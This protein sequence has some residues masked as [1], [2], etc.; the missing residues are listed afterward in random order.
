MVF[1]NRAS[2]GA[3][4]SLVL[5]LTI[6]GLWSIAPSGA[7]AGADFGAK[8]LMA[9]QGATMKECDA[10]PTLVAIPGG[11]FMMGSEKS[12]PGHEKDESPR[13]E[14]TIRPFAI[15]QTEVTVGE[16]RRFSEE[17]GR[18]IHPRLRSCYTYVTTV[19]W[20][21]EGNYWDSPGFEQSD[22]HPVVC[23]STED[24]EDYVA[25]LNS[26][27]EGDPYR[28]PSE[29]EWEY[30]ARAGAKSAFWWGGQISSDQA[31]YK[32]DLVYDKG[33]AGEYRGGTLPVKSFKPNPFGLYQ[34]HGNVHE[35]T[36]DCENPDYE[37]APTDG[38]AWRDGGFFSK[39]DCGRRILRGGGWYDHPTDLRLAGRIRY[40]VTDRIDSVGFRIVRNLP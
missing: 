38:S 25:W 37:G 23:V 11:A 40:A 3:R 9:A 2:G 34:V 21:I 36:A 24:A 27:V 16:Y 33:S 35:W 32:G 26:K 14:V 15:G 22:D 7:A 18:R 30:A 28:L 31:N 4:K 20:E 12:E 17:T 8:L 13:H 1:Y 5:T 10:C 39:G 6:L 19:W 29:A